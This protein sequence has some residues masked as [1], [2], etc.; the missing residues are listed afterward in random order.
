MSSSVT[1]SIDGVEDLTYV[2]VKQ[3]ARIYMAHY[4]DEP[5]INLRNKKIDIIEELKKR[6]SAIE[7]ESDSEVEETSQPDT[8]VEISD[9]E[10]L[11]SG[12]DSETLKSVSD[13]CLGSKKTKHND[14]YNSEDGS[15]YSAT[16][17]S[18]NVRTIIGS[19]QNNNI[20]FFYFIS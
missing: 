20:T 12:S 9:N 19:K 3:Q 14:A 17:Q 18:S 8:E 16:S 4:P 1:F 2:E 7:C 11:K 13:R 6:Y 15:A 5:R 10:T